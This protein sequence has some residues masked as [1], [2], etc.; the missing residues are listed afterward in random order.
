MFDQAVTV[1]QR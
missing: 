1:N